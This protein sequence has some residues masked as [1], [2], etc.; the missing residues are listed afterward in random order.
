[1][2]RVCVHLKAEGLV[3]GVYF[4]KTMASVASAEGVTGWVRNMADGS[5]EALIEGE[6]SAVS[7]VVD[8][9]RRGPP[10]ARVDSLTVK[11]RLPRS[12]KG[13]RIAG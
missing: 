1:M 12:L 5:V 11:R 8:W 7:R 10:R 3:H 13:F 9:A 6:E 2:A 4:R